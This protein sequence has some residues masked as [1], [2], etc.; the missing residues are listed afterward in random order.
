MTARKMAAFGLAVVLAFA[1]VGCGS[2]KK[3]DSAQ[4]QAVDAQQSTTTSTT[5]SSS[6]DT[7]GSSGGSGTGLNSL[8]DCISASAAYASLFVQ[9][10][11]F[12]TGADQAQL[13]QFE[14]QTQDLKAKIP[15]SLQA[16]FQTVANAY[17]QYADTLKGVNF[18]DI[19]NP[20]TQQKL[21]DASSALDSQDVKDAQDRIDS[22]FK[23]NCGG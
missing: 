7:S 9:A 6:G 14:Q 19:L 8:G 12:A 17:K 20:A 1:A 18:G 11:G 4:S 15:D 2:S 21:Q 10:S 23:Q 13:D 5:A 16:D 3:N 22:Y